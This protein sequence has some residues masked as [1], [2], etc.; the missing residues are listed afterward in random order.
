MGRRTAPLLLV[1]VLSV[2][3]VTLAASSAEYDQVLPSTVQVP[4]GFLFLHLP[5][6]SAHPSERWN[7]DVFMTITNN[8]I[9]SDNF[10][11]MLGSRTARAP[12]T[13]ADIEG[14][15][16]A[17]PGEDYYYFDGEVMTLNAIIRTPIT[18]TFAIAARLS[19]VGIT[20]GEGM[21]GFVEGFHDTFG[22]GQA[23][24]DNVTRGSIT[25]AVRIDG[26]DETIVEYDRAGLGDP[27]A[28]AMWAPD[29][30]ARAWRTSFAAGLKV[31][32]GSTP[33]RLST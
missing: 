9:Y 30:G 20:G 25:A 21:D 27:I 22:L 8:F 13:E 19:A 3:P 33:K 15:A 14:I 17:N 23:Y 4:Y 12:I 11:E 28:Y 6:F 5:A 7:Y 16:A 32:I 2:A 29:W 10:G 1:S 24:R 18:R 26:L 31:P